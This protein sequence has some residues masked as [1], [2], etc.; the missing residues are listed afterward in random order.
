MLFDLGVSSPQLDTPER[1]FSYNAD[2]PLDMRM[3]TGAALTAHEVVNTWSEE[4]L[5]EMLYAYGEERYAPQI[6]SA[7][8]RQRKQHTIETTLELAE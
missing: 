8:E 6:A 1:G 3:D 5:K 4:R 2:A 7:I